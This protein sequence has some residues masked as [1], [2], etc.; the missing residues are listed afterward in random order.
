MS[1]WQLCSTLPFQLTI[2]SYM[3][4]FLNYPLNWT[5]LFLKSHSFYSNF[6]CS[7][8]DSH[9]IYL[10]YI[11]SFSSTIFP[12]L[13]FPR[14]IYHVPCRQW[15]LNNGL[16]KWIIELLFGTSVL[17]IGNQYELFWKDWPKHTLCL[18]TWLFLFNLIIY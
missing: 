13:S 7:Y 3:K 5:V 1:C 8:F 9:S 6:W 4:T 17:A 18:L 14:S 12:H 2:T 11:S 16:L 15:L 10:H